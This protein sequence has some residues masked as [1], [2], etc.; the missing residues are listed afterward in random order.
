MTPPRALAAVLRRLYALGLALGLASAW[1]AGAAEP[2]I[3]AARA[4]QVKSAYVLNFVRYTEWP[5]GTRPDPC[6]VTVLGRSNLGRALERM[7]GQVS[8]TKGCRLELRRLAYPTRAADGSIDP[9]AYRRF[10]QQVRDTHVLYLGRSQAPHLDELL[11]RAGPGVLTIS[12]IPGFAARGGMIELVIERGRVVFEANEG[13]IDSA[14]L[15]L[16]SKALMLA[17]HVYREEGR[18]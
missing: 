12:D 16:S 15:K 1:P 17:R 5:A 13:A 11:G 14:G 2:P 8:A 6:V 10:Y 3:D 4:A 9:A 7:L 18:P